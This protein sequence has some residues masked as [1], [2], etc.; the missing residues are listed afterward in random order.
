V[1]DACIRAA[2]TWAALRCWDPRTV[3]PGASVLLSINRFERKKGLPLAL[4][5]LA[6][7]RRGRR[8][9]A[10]L[11][12]VLAGGYDPRLA[13]NVEH[14]AELRAQADALGVSDAVTFLPSFGD[15]QKAALLAAATLVLYTPQARTPALSCHVAAG[16][17]CA[18]M[19]P[20]AATHRTSTSGSCRLRPWPRSAPWLPAP[21]AAPPR[22]SWTASRASCASP[23][24][25][26]LL[27]RCGAFWLTQQAR[28]P[29]A[30]PCPT[31]RI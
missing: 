11:H 20:V 28:L 16:F 10:P 7:L 25:L 12:L 5:C 29:H 23:P 17:A 24:Q 27:R 22:A 21:V 4:Q 18:L 9:A 15:E 6:E 2:A 14:L 31:V 1:R 3:L 19:Q 30:R 26:H 13:E 8:P